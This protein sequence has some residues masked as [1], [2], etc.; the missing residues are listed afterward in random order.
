M[1]TNNE[2]DPF[3]HLAQIGDEEAQRERELEE[4]ERL[5]R[6]R[7]LAEVQAAA[8]A[9]PA[10]GVDEPIESVKNAREMSKNAAKYLIPAGIVV[11]VAWVFLSPDPGQKPVVA[12]PKG[13]VN[14]NQQLANY[15]NLWDGLQND[16]K[17][18]AQAKVNPPLPGQ[19]ALPLPAVTAG[20]VAQMPVA[21]GMPQTNNGAADA[22]RAKKE[23]E[24][25]QREME[26]RASPLE[27]PGQIMTA[28]T[29]EPT[30]LPDAAGPVSMR[31]ASARAE[32]NEYAA[33]MNGA[34]SP[35]AAGGFGS[36]S[37]GAYAG[38]GSG[39]AG[40]NGFGQAGYG[41]NGAY[42]NGGTPSGPTRSLDHE[43]MSE[44]Q[45]ASSEPVQVLRQQQATG[46]YIVNEGTPIQAVL[47]S[48]I[49]SE[50]AG[51]VTAVVTYDVYDGLGQ[52]AV[53]IP[54]GSKLIGKYSN[55][56]VPGQSRLLIAMTRMIL[57]NGTW[58]SLAGAN[59]TDQIGQSGLDADVDNH[60]FKIFGTSL[61]LGAASYLLP[62]GDRSITSTV[63][64]LGG[65]QSGGS[66]AGQALN[67]SMKTML[68]RNKRINPTLSRE[69][70]TEFSFMAARDMTFTPYRR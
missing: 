66:I 59:G 12:Q 70:G 17:K 28:T 54:K 29:P 4:Q 60:F 26:I 13:E 62:S 55:Q 16:A 3:S 67:D 48:G 31:Q 15:Q 57:P 43:F 23:A 9:K 27:A 58:I 65:I 6:E 51:G 52:G 25:A 56:V 45:A 40:S 21:T 7:E 22:E 50:R 35:G 20:P 10:S 68:E 32:A 5:R 49:M 53:L 8:D 41:V 30:R 19:G 14:G 39:A 36:S 64:G 63:G 44:Q 11:L 24:L 1:P 61:I 47:L 33:R 2:R 42:A 18:A 69:P 37:A 34:G 38:A 46:Q